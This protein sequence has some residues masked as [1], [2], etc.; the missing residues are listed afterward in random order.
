MIKV[1]LLKHSSLLIG[2]EMS[3]HAGFAE[4][5]NDII[6]AAASVL[7]INTVNSIETF[8]DDLFDCTVSDEEGL[9]HFKLISNNISEK[10]ELL[11]NAFQL[12][13]QGI[14]QQYGNTYIDIIT[15]EV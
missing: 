9:L 5:G 14:E 3:G 4:Y 6:C 7:A 10:S 13:I 15:E 2:F 1:T 11:L 8:T 12:G